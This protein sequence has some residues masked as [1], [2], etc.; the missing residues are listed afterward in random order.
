MPNIIIYT[1]TQFFIDKDSKFTWSNI[2]NTF[3]QERFA[4]ELEHL[5]AY[6]NINKTRKNQIV[7]KFPVMPCPEVIE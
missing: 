6:I 5:H 7:G 4:K 3:M 1:Y 2:Y